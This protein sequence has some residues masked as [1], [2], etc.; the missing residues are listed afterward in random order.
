MRAAVDVGSISGA[1][2]L[3]GDV[4]QDVLWKEAIGHADVRTGTLMEP[5]AMFWAA[6][7]LSKPLTATAAMMMV[8]N[9]MLDLD[10]PVGRYLSKLS[11]VRPPFTVRQCLSHTSGLP[12]AS[13]AEL[14][15]RYGGFDRFEQSAFA[16]YR[17]T[18][19]DCVYDGLP[20]SDAVA[21]YAHEKLL[22]LPGERY[23]YSNAGFNVVGRVV[24]VLAGDEYASFIN[25]HLLK[26][27]RMLD[28]TLWPTKEQLARLANCYGT[29]D[30]GGGDG[31][32]LREVLFPQLTPPYHDLTRG[33]S[34]AG[35]FFSTAQDMARFGRMI[36]RGGELD[37]QRFLSERAVAEM[38]ADHAGPAGLEYGLGW[39]ICPSVPNDAASGGFGHSGATGVGLYLHPP[40]RRLV[41][42]LVHQDGGCDYN[43][44]WFEQRRELLRFPF[45]P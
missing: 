3:V 20:L 32:S 44:W 41:V 21:S 26:P 39:R 15:Q 10:A 38:T 2:A 5:N 28:T 17:R 37:G 16:S 23:W 18:G 24:E 30:G 35:G 29:G 7:S 34:P 9:G 22:S 19:D 13:M 6:S 14:E 43:D 12:F 8:D 36:L 4:N 27:L 31:S 33:V 42:L 40:T 1:V 45:D 25:Q 11:N